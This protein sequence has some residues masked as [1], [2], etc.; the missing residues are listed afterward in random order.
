MEEILMNIEWMVVI[1]STVVAYVFGWWWYS[2]GGWGKVWRKG[3]GG[4]VMQHPM[5]MSMSAQ[6]GATFVYAI[7]VN[8]AAADGH[9]GHVV[10]V[11]FA[12]AGFIKANGLFGGKTK[13]A[14]SVETIYVLV[15]GIIM[16]AINMVL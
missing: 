8:L 15:M 13:A 1:V 16:V 14:I 3:K 4:E 9:L 6:L 12:I 5:W 2:D 11:T 7:I 10:L